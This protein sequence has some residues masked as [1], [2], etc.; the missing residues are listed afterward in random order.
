MQ[1]D[2][3]KPSLPPLLVHLPSSKAVSQLSGEISSHQE[4]REACLL[5]WDLHL[6][7]VMVLQIAAKDK[8]SP[9]LRGTNE[10][11]RNIL[12]TQPN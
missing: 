3:R 11:L 6:R 7:A 9:C 10:V 8:A 1:M 12:R 2:S 4:L 5:E